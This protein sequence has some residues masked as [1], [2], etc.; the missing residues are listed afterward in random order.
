MPAHFR[1]G[2]GGDSETF[3]EGLERLGSALDELR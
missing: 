1:I 2:L 3:V